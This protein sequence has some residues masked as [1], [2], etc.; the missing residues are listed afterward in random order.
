MGLTPQHQSAQESLTRPQF[1]VTQVSP[2][3][4]RIR[5][6]VTIPRRPLLLLLLPVVAAP[7]ARL[8]VRQMSTCNPILQTPT[9]RTSLAPLFTTTLQPP[10]V[11][12]DRLHSVIATIVS[13]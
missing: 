1:Q 6:L 10:R 3:V 13:S 11:P 7:L 8:L 5:T 12:A 2:L 9:T 4:Q